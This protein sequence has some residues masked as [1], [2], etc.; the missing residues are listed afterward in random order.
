MPYIGVMTSRAVPEEKR[1]VV[2][3]SLS[4]AVATS[5]GKPER[6]VM[7]SLVE[8]GVVF[9]GEAVDA[10]FVDV[11][12]IGGLSQDVNSDMTHRIC[13]LLEAVLGLEPAN[14]YVTFTDVPATNW[15]CN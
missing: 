5:T 1:D 4:A 12:G 13:A 8:G 7:A 14:V 6:Y 10:A 2:L 11:R 15:G 9:G 3:K